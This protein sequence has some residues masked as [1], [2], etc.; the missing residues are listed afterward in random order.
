MVSRMVPDDPEVTRVRRTL[1]GLLGVPATEGNQ[2]TIL[3]NGDRTF[4]AMLAGIAAAERS[5]DLM[6]FV[7]KEGDIAERFTEALAERSRAG[8]RVRVLL[9]KLG[10][11]GMKEELVE[12]L[13]SAGAQVEWFREPTRTTKKLSDQRTHRK[14]LVVDELVAFTGGVNIGGH[15]QGDAR[16]GDEWRDTHVRV[17]GP[18]VD[19]LRA[20]FFEN[21]AETRRPLF[22]DTD[23]FPPHST[24]GGHTVQVV[25]SAAGLAWSDTGTCFAALVLLARRRLRI[26]TPYFV[27]DGMFRERLCEAARRGV[28]VQVLIPGD[29]IDHPV[30]KLAGEA[31]FEEL[32]EAGV[33]I[34]TY[35]KTM[36]HA[37]IITVDGV[38][39]YVGSANFDHRS[40]TLN[41]EAGVMLLDRC[42]VEELDGDFDEDL[43]HSRSLDLDEWR[44]R[45]ALR[46]AAEAVTGLFDHKM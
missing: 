1:E 28:E 7:Y 45:G 17:V 4:G 24:D 21:W 10:A 37:K 25:R 18:A 2:V 11:R 14:I 35:E 42:L 19:G 43:R 3:R 6:A 36:I 30:V 5:V 34:R 20:A 33:C 27:P 15:W 39:A 46:K 41:D 31:D 13:R 32:L 22:D 38:A 9:D 26:V 16:N 29:H 23:R 8:V 44:N 12:N 40:V